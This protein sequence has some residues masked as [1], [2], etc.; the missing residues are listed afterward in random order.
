MEM[1]SMLP[2]KNQDLMGNMLLIEKKKVLGSSD[3]EKYVYFLPNVMQCLSEYFKQNNENTAC[4]TN[5]NDKNYNKKRL[6][7]RICATVLIQLQDFLKLC[8]L[9]HAIQ[10]VPLYIG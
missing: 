7:N 6:K 8:N 5:S 1:M 2:R 4:H 10:L 9:W 3:H